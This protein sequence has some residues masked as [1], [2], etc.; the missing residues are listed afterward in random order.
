MGFKSQLNRRFTMS[1][2]IFALYALALTAA[3]AAASTYSALPA[4]PV[5]G[6]FVTRD[7]VWN[8]GPAACQ[9][10]TQESRPLVLCQS[11]AKRAGR[12]GSFIVDGRALAAADL[13]RCNA[14]AKP[15]PAQ[16]L[17]AQ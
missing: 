11:L 17:A 15:Q 1:R 5:T 4:A 10:A 13:E 12:I 8:C 14:S 7:I 16:A 6:R 2:S 9:G 3:P